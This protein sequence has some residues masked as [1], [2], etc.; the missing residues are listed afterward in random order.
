MIKDGTLVRQMSTSAVSHDD[1][2][3]VLVAVSGLFPGS[4]TRLKCL[5]LSDT[6]LLSSFNHKRNINY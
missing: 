2:A 1:E 4:H 3:M 5:F 6:F